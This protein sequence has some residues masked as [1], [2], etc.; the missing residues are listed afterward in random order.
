[1]VYPFGLTSREW[2]TV[3][4]S[5]ISISRP[6]QTREVIRPPIA[7]RR[8]IDAYAGEDFASTVREVLTF[9]H[10]VGT[11]LGAADAA[12][13]RRHFAI[14]SWYEWMFWDAAW[15]LDPLCQPVVRHPDVP[16]AHTA[17]PQG[18]RDR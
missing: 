5:L 3:V 7:I 4:A 2:C 13:A 15:R 17:Q 11:D 1:M 18:I 16:R 14:T 12:R 8:W 6:G 9:A 10:S